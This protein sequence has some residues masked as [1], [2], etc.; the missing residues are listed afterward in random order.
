MNICFQVSSGSAE[1]KAVEVR[2]RDGCRDRRMCVDPW[3]RLYINAE[4]L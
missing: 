1:H 2:K 3:K 4:L